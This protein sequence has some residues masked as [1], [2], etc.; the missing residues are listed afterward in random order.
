[1][2]IVG[3]DV[4]KRSHEAIIIDREGN[5]VKKAFNF[6]NDANGFSKRIEQFLAYVK[7]YSEKKK[8]FCTDLKYIA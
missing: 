5:I 7:K 1:M 3:V 8:Y 6:K 2:F 4:A